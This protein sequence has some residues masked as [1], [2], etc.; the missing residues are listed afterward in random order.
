M[1]SHHA[2]G[3]NKVD[4][5]DDQIQPEDTEDRDRLVQPW[6][7]GLGIADESCRSDDGDERDTHHLKTYPVD[8]ALQDKPV[9]TS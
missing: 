6:V 7:Y 1:Q 4:Q 2:L 8:R 9:V 5:H 3:D